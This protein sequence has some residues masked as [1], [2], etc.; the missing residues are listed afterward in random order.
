MERQVEGQRGLELRISNAVFSK[1][2]K[3]GRDQGM[4]PQRVGQ[5]LFDQA[6]EAACLGK[7]KPAAEAVLAGADIE[8]WKG[9]H[10]L[11]I[12]KLCEA[13]KALDQAQKTIASKDAMLLDQA[14][15]IREANAEIQ[16]LRQR[17]EE[18]C[19]PPTTGLIDQ[20][21]IDAANI[22]PSEIVFVS[23]PAPSDSLAEL[24]ARVMPDSVPVSIEPPPK[25]PLPPSPP[26]PAIERLG[27]IVP[28][29]AIKGMNAAGNSPAE[30]ARDLGLDVAIVRQVLG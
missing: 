12:E 4:T 25:P 19:G 22:K 18:E 6:Y 11:A 26:E 5:A 2:I 16:Q 1:L 17:I 9:R 23:N 29:R 30:I 27:P 13:E 10:D 7:G 24:Y 28:V 15:Q 14:R 20:A 8:E 3:M 21:T